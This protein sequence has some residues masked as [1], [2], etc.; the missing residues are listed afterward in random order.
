MHFFRD[1]GV[2]IALESSCMPYTLRFSVR[3]RPERTS[4]G[5]LAQEKQKEL[6]SI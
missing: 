5:C 2:G 6:F 4:I 3:C 1:S